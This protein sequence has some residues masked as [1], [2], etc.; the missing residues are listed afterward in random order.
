MNIEQ[1]NPSHHTTLTSVMRASKA[2]WGYGKLQLEKWEDELTVSQ[3]YIVNNDV[4]HLRLDDKIV[5]FYSYESRDRTIKLE[6]LFLSP[7]YIGRRLGARMMTDFMTRVEPLSKM[8]ILDSDPHAEVFYSNFSFK[9]ISL[10]PTSIPNRYMPIMVYNNTNKGHDC[11]FETDRFIVRHLELKDIDGFYDMQSNPN[12]MKYVKPAMNLKE[13]EKELE[14]F[15]DHYDSRDKLFRIWA[16]IEKESRSFLGICGVYENGMKEL[17][18]AYRLRQCHWGKGY[19]KE[20][21]KTLID[22]CFNTLDY[23]R[24]K[25]YVMGGNLGSKKILDQLMFFDHKIYSKKTKSVE[26]VYKTE[27]KN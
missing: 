18:I 1:S 27:K 16:V 2:H 9:T 3:E 7:D 10:T 11:L 26:Y 19:G 23:D 14:R 13:S 25:A 5:G 6:N 4:Y 22:F 21:A 8:I 12:V 15:I 24:L 20:I 17:E